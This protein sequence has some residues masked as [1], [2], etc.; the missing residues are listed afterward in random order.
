M[1]AFAVLGPRLEGLRALCPAPRQS[2]SWLPAL[3]YASFSFVFSLECCRPST[4]LPPR[5]Q[6]RAHQTS[7]LRSLGVCVASVTQS[8]FGEC[9]L[10]RRGNWVVC[11]AVTPF[12]LAKRLLV[13]RFFGRGWPA[14]V[15]GHGWWVWAPVTP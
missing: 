9:Q 15:L 11:P 10:L 14:P 12:L 8:F 1:T 13:G 3:V 5:I 6:Q 4:V 2:L 7:S